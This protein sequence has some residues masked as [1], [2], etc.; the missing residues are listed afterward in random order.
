MELGGGGGYSVVRSSICE[1]IIHGV[2]RV[3][4]E[5]GLCIEHG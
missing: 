5:K 1:T 2:N 4:G 3:T